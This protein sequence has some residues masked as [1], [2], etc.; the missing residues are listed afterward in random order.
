VVSATPQ[1]RVVVPAA[2]QGTS[3]TA[4]IEKV[5]LSWSAP[6]ED[7]GAALTGYVVQRETADGWVEV[8]TPTDTTLE[9]TGL[10]AGEPASFRVA[11]VNEAGRG[12]WS[13][14][15]TA[16]PLAKPVATVP[17]APTGLAA[18]V[19]SNR[20]TIKLTWN[21]PANDGGAPVTDY[22]VQ[23]TVFPLFGWYVVNDG[24]SANPSATVISP[25]PGLKLYY[26]VAA[27]N[28]AGLGA[29][30]TPLRAG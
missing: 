15:V 14:V 2:P 4:G 9:V 20:R 30:S 17:S 26:R 11:A 28:S 18:R 21:A 27:R 13:D 16:T 6:A 8:G 5:A 7:G 10:T 3:A 1:P 24:V 22:V 19:S 29:W 25:L 23:V 12:A